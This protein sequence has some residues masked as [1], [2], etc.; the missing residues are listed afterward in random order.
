MSIEIMIAVGLFI[1]ANSYFSYK[2][3]FKE[4]QFIGITGLALTLKIH[5]I[6]KSKDTIHNYEQLPTTIKELLEDPQAVLT[7][8]K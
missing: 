6:L 2:S 3:G 1:L 5:N 4:G 8:S 7:E